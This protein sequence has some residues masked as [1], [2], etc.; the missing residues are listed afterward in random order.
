MITNPGRIQEAE[1]TAE[2]EVLI[3]EASMTE[4][5]IDQEDIMMTLM[6]K[7]TPDL[8]TTMMMR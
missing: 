4:W 1:D 7:E 2:E 8:N 6:N 5:I 3:E